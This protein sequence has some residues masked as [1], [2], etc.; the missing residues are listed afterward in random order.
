MS[1]EDDSETLVLDLNRLTNNQKI[2]YMKNILT[3]FDTIERKDYGINEKPTPLNIALYNKIK[4]EAKQKFDVYPSIYANAWLVKEYKKKGGTYSGQKNSKQGLLRWFDE[5]WINVCKLP[6]IVQCGRPS[7]SMS[8]VEWKK[9]YPYCR[10]R[11]KISSKTPKTASTLSKKEIET[12]CKNKK[13]SPHK[14]IMPTK[15]KKRRSKT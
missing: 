6:K 9:S 13:K 8:M 4:S 10:P 2:T 11:Y 12:R 14:K 5:E 7:T 3:L 15:K 1:V